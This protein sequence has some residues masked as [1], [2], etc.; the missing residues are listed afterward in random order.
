MSIARQLYQL[1]ELDLEI[2]SHEQ[3]LERLV[4]QLGESKAVIQARDR[5]ASAEQR[6]EELKKQ[7]RS[8]EWETDDLTSKIKKAEDELYS[9]RVRNPKELM[10][11]QQEVEALKARR[12]QFEDRALALMEQADTVTKDIV[13]GRRE[14]EQ[15]EAEWRRQQKQLSAD[16]EKLKAVLADL[17]QRRQALAAQIDPEALEFYQRLRKQRGKAVAKVEQ[18]ICRGCQISLPT[19]DLQRV[20]GGY[21]VQCSSCNRIL[22]QG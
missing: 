8:A 12:S 1:Q 10:S 18:G 19:T 2:E 5:L 3:A 15:M 4:S 7:Q 13:A 9:G 14:L 21:L 22:Y 16:I 17:T 6:L 20:R 11:L